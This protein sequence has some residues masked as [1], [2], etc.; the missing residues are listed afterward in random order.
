MINLDLCEPVQVAPPDAHIHRWTLH[1]DNHR[2]HHGVV[3]ISDS[4]NYT[5]RYPGGKQLRNQYS[6]LACLGL[7]F[8]DFSKVVIG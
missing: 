8:L 3:N 4:R 1:D 5:L 6:E 7:I 2:H